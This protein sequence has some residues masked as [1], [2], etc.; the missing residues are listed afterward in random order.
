MGI[1]PERL[2]PETIA[3]LLTDDIDTDNGVVSEKE[4]NNI[5]SEMDDGS[6][7]EWCKRNGFPDGPCKACGEKGLKSDN[8]AIVKKANF[9]MNTVKPK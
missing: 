4:M 6:F 2:D 7:T 8:P 5:L 9:Y 3:K 1:N